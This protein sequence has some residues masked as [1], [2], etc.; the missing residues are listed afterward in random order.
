MQVFQHQTT[1]FNTTTLGAVER[2]S[3]AIEHMSIGDIDGDGAL[4]IVIAQ[5]DTGISI[6]INDGTGTR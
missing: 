4:D 6:L 1:A 3:I 5:M 2:I